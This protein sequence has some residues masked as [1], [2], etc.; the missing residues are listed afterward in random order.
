ME[1]EE[2]NER[3][4]QAQAEIAHYSALIA[5]L[6]LPVQQFG[7]AHREMSISVDNLNRAFFDSLVAAGASQRA[8]TGFGVELGRFTEEEA[9]AAWI[10]QLL[11]EKMGV[12]ARK[13]AEGD[14][15]VGQARTQLSNYADALTGVREVAT[16]IPP[17]VEAMKEAAA[18]E[19]VV[20]ISSNVEEE[21]GNIRRSLEDL[22]QTEWK[23]GIGMD[24][25]DF[26]GLAE[27]VGAQEAIAMRQDMQNEMAAAP[28]EVTMNVNPELTAARNARTEM[29][30]TML[31][32]MEV[33]PEVAAALSSRTTLGRPFEADLSFV[34]HVAA[35]TRARNDLA[36]PITVPVT[37]APQNSPTSAP[38]VPEFLH[39]GFV[40]G[41]TY[42]GGAVPALVHEGE[43]VLSRG[44]VDRLG[45]A[46]LDGINQGG[47][48]GSQV[49]ITLNNYGQMGAA[50][51]APRSASQQTWSELAQIMRR[52]GVQL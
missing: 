28:L 10:T 50:Q 40:G 33:V 6:N 49:N 7:V 23:I 11:H 36:R 13:V 9:E 43:Y 30:K 12:L 1:Q 45:R 19:I 48:P 17:A 8:I 51:P 20:G 47:N 39:G 27:R 35:A 29:E 34:P 3:M 46:F 21:A 16:D 5:G 4:G 44:A 38:A 22:M 26:G 32:V 41:Q 14:L 15:T 25:K 24:F 42:G 31:P 2:F 52:Y 18:E 37:Y